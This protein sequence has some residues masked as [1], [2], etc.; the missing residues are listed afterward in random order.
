M[1]T[2]LSRSISNL[3][4][5]KL[6]GLLAEVDLRSHLLSLGFAERVSRGGWIART[7]GANI[8]GHSTIALFPETL[9]PSQLYPPHRPLPAP[10]HGLHTICSTLHQS[11]ISSFFCAATIAESENPAALHWN[12]VQ[13]GLPVQQPY[14]PLIERLGGCG[15]A[16]RTRAYNYL[17]YSANVAD[18]PENAVPE[19]FTKEHLRIAFSNSY[20]AEISDIDGLFW[21]NQ[22]TYPIEV[23]EKTPAHSTDVG[24]YFGLDVG[25]FVKLAFYAA[26]RGNLHSLYVVREIDNEHDRNLVQ[27]SFVTFDHL[28]QRASWVSRTGG[29][30]MLGGAS[31]VVRIPKVEFR[32]LNAE[33]IATL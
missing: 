32:P 26:K 27:W 8:F 11:G 28:A 18:I 29:P 20:M 14:A 6:R 3:N 10:D 13:L 7:K 17:R 9:Q 2:Y 21:G 24:E 25:P 12:A 23:K 19:E 16:N 31:S 1:R 5:N 33:N 4:Q 22:F 15:F 30:G